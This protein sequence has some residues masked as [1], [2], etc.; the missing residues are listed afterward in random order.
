MPISRWNGQPACRAVPEERA[1]SR[2][3]EPGRT[4][5]HGAV[6]ASVD[7]RFIPRVGGRCLPD[8]IVLRASHTAS[9]VPSSTPSAPAQ[10]NFG[11]RSTSTKIGS[12][13]PLVK[14]VGL[15]RPRTPSLFDSRPLERSRVRELCNR[16][17]NLEHLDFRLG[18]SRSRHEVASRVHCLCAS[19]VSATCRSCYRTT[20][21]LAPLFVRTTHPLRVTDGWMRGPVRRTGKALRRGWLECDR[22]AASP[23][24]PASD[25]RTPAGKS[26]SRGVALQW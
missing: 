16:S 13:S 1:V 11:V 7:V 15:P 14:E 17:F 26:T 24:A 3:H 19:L 10:L 12:P 20:C 5:L 23:R 8:P 2:R 21:L 18:C 9:D 6:R 4:A 25:A 22:R